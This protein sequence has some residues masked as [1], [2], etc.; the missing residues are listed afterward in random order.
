MYTRNATFG[1][2]VKKDLPKAKFWIQIAA[3]SGYQSAVDVLKQNK[4]GLNEVKIATERDVY[5]GREYMVPLKKMNIGVVEGVNDT[6]PPKFDKEYYNPLKETDS[7]PAH[8]TE[9]TSVQTTENTKEDKD[10]IK[11]NI[12]NAASGTQSESVMPMFCAYCVQKLI[13]GIQFC[14]YCRQKDISVAGGSSENQNNINTITNSNDDVN[15]SSD[16]EKQEALTVTQEE[17]NEP[18]ST[19]TVIQTDS[20]WRIF[21]LDN[22]SNQADITEDFFDVFEGDD[23][24]GDSGSTSFTNEAEYVN[25]GNKIRE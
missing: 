4:Y 24:S 1:L 2:G 15:N 20:K 12:T 6:E 18:V 3:N 16:Q 14:P 5:S 7:K 9:T 23:T 21:P 22:T 13:S 25:E 17:H 8:K 11:N 10:Q 19:S